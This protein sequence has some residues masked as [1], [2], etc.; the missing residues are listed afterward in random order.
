MFGCPGRALT[1]KAVSPRARSLHW[2]AR[3]VHERA[4]ALRPRAR[5]G[6]RADRFVSGSAQYPLALRTQSDV[7]RITAA[8]G[9]TP[10]RQ[11]SA[12]LQPGLT[13]AR[14]YD[15]KY[16]AAYATAL[17]EL[18]LRAAGSGAGLP[19]A[20]FPCRRTDRKGE[21]AAPSD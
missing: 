9:V 11:R 15:G 14:R 21:E 1:W 19:P 17:R 10:G 20:P 7:T 5:A 8:G 6:H 16:R 2:R 13:K 18:G 12:T 4:R 3:S